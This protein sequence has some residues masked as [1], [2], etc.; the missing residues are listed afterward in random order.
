MQR[1][2][3]LEFLRAAAASHWTAQDQASHLLAG[4]LIYHV[5][6]KSFVI[7]LSNRVFNQRAANV[8][9]KHL[10]IGPAACRFT[11]MGLPTAFAEFSATVE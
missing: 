7:K 4:G 10:Y 11:Y 8:G 5:V 3:N 1:P 6:Y 2:K 9:I